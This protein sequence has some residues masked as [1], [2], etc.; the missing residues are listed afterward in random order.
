MVKVKKWDRK[1][2]KAARANY[3]AEIKSQKYGMVTN[4]LYVMKDIYRFDK[5]MFFGCFIFAFSFYFSD[6]LAVYT[7]KY[8]VELA[9]A[10]FGSLRLVMICLLLFVGNHVIGY[11]GNAVGNYQDYIGFAKCSNHIMEKIMKKNMTTDYEN[12]E[13]SENNDSLNKAREGM[14]IA[15]YNTP[16]NV[17]GTIR[18]TINFFTY[19]AILSV[20]DIRLVPIIAVPAALSYLIERHKMQWV[21]NMADNWQVYDRQLE[22]INSLSN[23]FSNAKDIRIFGMQTWFEKIFARSFKQR[24]EWFRQQDAWEFR[25]NVLRSF[26][27]FIGDFAAYAYVIYLVVNGSIGAGDF[28]LYFNSIMRL[29]NAVK[30]WCNNISGYQ[31]ISNNVNY[32]RAYLEMEDKTNRGEGASVPSGKCEVEF[33]NVSYTY[34]GAESPTIKNLSFTLHKG[35]KLAF[36]GLNGVGKTTIVKLMCGLYDPTDGEIFLN[37]V[38]AKEYNR[39]E[40]F[41]LFSTVFQ[42]VSELPVSIA[43]NITGQSDSEIDRERMFDCMK[44][45]DIY[46]KIM[47]LPEKESTPLCRGVYENSTDLSGGEK[48]KTALAKALYKDAPVLLLDEPTA[49]LDPIAEQKMYM[50]YMEF[51]K[52]KSCVFISHRLASTRF[53]DRIL[54]I[55]DGGIAEYGSHVQLMESGGKYA[56]LFNIQSSYYND[57]KKEVGEVE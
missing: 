44:K 3:R 9:A 34:F 47:S 46:D 2:K 43:E 25:H 28:V 14:F 17:R 53:C 38:N 13:K 27:G 33:R 52:E 42:D 20:L 39:E 11:I 48:Q 32:V 7:D 54:L 51:S 4:V 36:V 40:Y 16:L 23:D 41:R 30:D 24:L 10:G 8:V 55:E 19:S 22:Y 31:W 15:G 57:D 18:H 29:S 45:A 49:A 50:N 35:E 26:I 21:W 1:K 6:L 37:G 56:E 12:N 5:V